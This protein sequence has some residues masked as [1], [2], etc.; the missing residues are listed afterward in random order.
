MCVNSFA[1][2]KEAVRIAET[3]FALLKEQRLAEITSSIETILKDGAGDISSVLV[4]L[5][6]GEKL[7]LVSHFPQFIE[8]VRAAS[9]VEDVQAA[10]RA[11]RAALRSARIDEN[12]EVGTRNQELMRVVRAVAVAPRSMVREVVG[13]LRKIEN[14][15]EELWRV[16][17]LWAQVRMKA[18]ARGVL[19]RW[20]R[21]R[22]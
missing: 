8:T 16:G 13:D 20:R 12:P 7:D 1:D 4:R 10:S 21:R 19:R 5:S 6:E 22:R 15:P 2:L 17:L 11:A 3:R 9:G 14:P 18:S